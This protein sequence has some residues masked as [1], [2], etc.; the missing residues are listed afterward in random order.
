MEIGKISNVG[1]TFY[2]PAVLIKYKIIA[3]YLIIRPNRTIKC[4][5]GFINTYSLRIIA[6]K[7]KI[8]LKLCD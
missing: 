5:H 1:D 7:L 3:S 6:F 8:K 4:F 2:V